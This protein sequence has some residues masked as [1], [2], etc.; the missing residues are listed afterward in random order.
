MKN[1]FNQFF[2]SK[3]LFFYN[4]HLIL[5]FLILFLYLSPFFFL[6]ENTFVLIHDMLDGPI[7]SYKVLSESGMIFG[8]SFSIVKQFMN[9]PRVSLGSELDF[10]LWLFYFFKPFLG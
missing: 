7:V 5:P 2:L 9:V 4:S 8:S 3:Y 10:I 1:N 6:A